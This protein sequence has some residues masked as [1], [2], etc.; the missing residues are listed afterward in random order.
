MKKIAIPL[1]VMVSIVMIASTCLGALQ[2]PP[3][4]YTIEQYVGALPNYKDI[5]TS[6]MEVAPSNFD[7]WTHRTW[8]I[9]PPPQTGSGVSTII[10]VLSGCSSSDYPYYALVYGWKD[11]PENDWDDNGYL[12]VVRWNASTGEP[13]N[14]FL[15][16]WHK[17]FH[18]GIIVDIADASLQDLPLKEKFSLSSFSGIALVGSIIA[19]V[20]LGAIVYRASKSGKLDEI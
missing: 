17:G 15:Y 11:Q 13:Y 9:A 1:I 10:N 18:D 19:L 20:A 16:E 7:N 8:Y 12:L 2:P 3:F 5:D 4:E 6:D 14:A